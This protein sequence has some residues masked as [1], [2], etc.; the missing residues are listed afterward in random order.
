MSQ[1]GTS[2][3]DIRSGGKRRRILGKIRNE[4]QIELVVTVVCFLLALGLSTKLI[5]ATTT[6]C[7]RFAL[8]DVITAVL[9]L[10]YDPN[11]WHGI[12]VAF[13]FLALGMCRAATVALVAVFAV[14]FV[15]MTL[16]LVPGKLIGT[17]MA[18]GLI[19]VYAFLLLIFPSTFAAFVIAKFANLKL[20]FAHELT[21]IR[22]S[23]SESENMDTLDVSASLNLI[24]IGSAISLSIVVC[25][26]LFIFA[27]FPN[28]V[29]GPEVFL[30][31]F[32][33]FAAPPIWIWLFI[34][35][36]VPELEDV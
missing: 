23:E 6:A 34:S 36:V 11:R 21:D 31:M 15:F 27:M 4:F 3:T 17:S 29:A 30:V 2:D 8:P 1:N 22:R 35:S 20:Y 13:L 9:I 32:G 26:S 16:G 18:T 24:A 14:V 28:A 33:A 19:I 25:S 5:V 12:A 7:L 10:K